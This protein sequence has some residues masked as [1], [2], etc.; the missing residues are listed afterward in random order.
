MPSRS[1]SFRLQPED[2]KRKA[3]SSKENT[4][5][6]NSTKDLDDNRPPSAT[7][8]DITNTTRD[9][10]DDSLQENTSMASNVRPDDGAAVVPSDRESESLSL[11]AGVVSSNIDDGDAV[12]DC[13][14]EDERAEVL[15]V[16]IYL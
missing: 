4:T 16:F 8:G 6:N 15:C 1:L 11:H 2:R 7:P 3:L 14:K 13:L 9:Y 5:L 12:E 10:E